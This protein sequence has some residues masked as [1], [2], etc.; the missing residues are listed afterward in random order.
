M[1]FLKTGFCLES[2]SKQST[3]RKK[4]SEEAKSVMYD[5][6]IQ[7][8]EFWNIFIHQRRLH[9]DIRNYGGNFVKLRKWEK[10]A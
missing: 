8:N 9:G 7:T 6:L 10:C 3:E 4:L 2:T 1:G 5:L